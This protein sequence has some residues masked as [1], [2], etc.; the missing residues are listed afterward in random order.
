MLTEEVRD[1]AAEKHTADKQ[2]TEKQTT[3]KQTTDIQAKENHA[4]IRRRNHTESSTAKI[5]TS[6]ST[7]SQLKRMQW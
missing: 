5:Y 6:M 7:N 2:T 1:Q 3:D 4:D